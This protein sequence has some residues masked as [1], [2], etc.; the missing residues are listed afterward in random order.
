MSLNL[1]VFQRQQSCPDGS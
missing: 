1:I